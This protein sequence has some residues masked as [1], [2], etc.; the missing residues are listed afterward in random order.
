VEILPAIGMGVWDMTAKAGLIPVAVALVAVLAGT[1]F[2]TD[3]A[4]AEG[5][6]L[7]APNAPAPQGSH[8]YYHTDQSTQ[9]KCWYVRAQDQPAQT[10]PGQQTPDSAGAAAGAAAA[11]S[12]AQADHTASD[13]LAH[14]VQAAL[15]AKSANTS[16]PSAQSGP[17]AVGKP[18][19]DTAAW[20]D[21]TPPASAVA[22][23][24]PPSAPVD[25]AMGQAGQFAADTAAQG[26]TAGGTLAVE[27]THPTLEMALPA[28]TAADDGLNAKAPDKAAANPGNLAA[29][30]D[31]MPTGIILAGAIALLIA[32]MFMRRAIT[33]AFA[34]R[35]P[36]HIERREPVLIES[37]AVKR[38]TPALL[39]HSPTL[40]PD[41]D[42]LDHRIDE[43]EDALRKLAR[44]LRQRRAT[45][46][47]TIAPFFSGESVE[48]RGRH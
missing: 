35:H 25:A 40:V 10:Q 6:C 19:T 13:R 23:P 30:Q 18:I 34:R 16:Q 21:P 12:T 41:H 47:K 44:R 22:W 42:G 20:T 36:V 27:S 2:A 39:A 37:T 17:R 26:A 24:D 14:R 33:R 15:A 45:P 3:S 7:E 11:P 31:D 32:G 43:V 4:R 9:R 38:P 8:W 1:G 29:S 5:P 46:F 48:I 28:A